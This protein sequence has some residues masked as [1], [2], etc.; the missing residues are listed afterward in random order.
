M[1]SEDWVYNNI[2]NMS[3]DQ[4]KKE[5]S[6]VV[7]D[8]KR[9]FRHDQIEAEGND[10][11]IN[12]DNQATSV[13]ISEGEETLKHAPTLDYASSMNSELS[14]KDCPKATCDEPLCRPSFWVPERKFC[15]YC[16]YRG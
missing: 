8:I 16:N 1:V 10:P 2:F 4:V 13:D 11:E 6:H 12:F 7:E 9:K 15:I 14:M 3:A 5:R